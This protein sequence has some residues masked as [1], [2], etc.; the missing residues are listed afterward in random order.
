MNIDPVVNGSLTFSDLP[1]EQGLE[2]AHRMSSHSTASFKEKLTYAGYNDVNV[3]YIICEKDKIIPAEVQMGMVEMIKA[4]SGRDV[5][6]HKLD[7]DHAPIVSRTED[8][9]AILEKVLNDT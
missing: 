9:S 2:W 7:C 5:Q 4:S 3:H 6:V 8:L 1:P